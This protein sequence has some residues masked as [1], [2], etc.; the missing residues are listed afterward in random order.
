MGRVLAVII[1]ILTLLSVLLFVSGKW[2]FPAAISDHAPALDRR[3]IHRGPGRP[4]LD[5]LEVS[6]YRRNRRPGSLFARQQ[7]SRGGLDHHH[8]S[9]LYFLGSDGPERLGVPAVA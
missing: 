8:R 2:W 3:F 5:D 6:R 1:W 4:R 7:S 9:Y